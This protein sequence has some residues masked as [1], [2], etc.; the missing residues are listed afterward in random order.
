M[1]VRLYIQLHATRARLQLE[2]FHGINKSNGNTETSSG[3]FQS[4]L[5]CCILC[6]FG[7]TLGQVSGG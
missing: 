7:S 6:S 4:S 1:K 5:V 3:L 2:T